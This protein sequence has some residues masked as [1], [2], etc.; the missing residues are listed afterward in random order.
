MAPETEETEPDT[1]SDARVSRRPAPGSRKKLGAAERA[2]H[3]RRR[4]WIVVGIAS[5]VSLLGVAVLVYFA[6]FHKSTVTGPRVPP[7]RPPLRV[8]SEGTGAYR[9]LVDALG[10]A[11]AG[12]RIVVETDLNENNVPVNPRHRNVIVEAMPNKTIVW[13]CPDNITDM[14]PDN[15]R[16]LTINGVEGFQ[17]K[18]ITLDGNKK[19]PVLISLY[20]RCPDLKLENLNL[21][22]FTRYGVQLTNC[23]GSKSAPVQL[24]DLTFVTLDKQSALFFTLDAQ[25]SFN[26]ITK[27][28]F[29]TVRGCRFNG[30]GGSKIKTPNLDFLDRT[31]I[32]LPAGVVPEQG[33]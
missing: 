1:D 27:I 19:A 4:F 11:Q 32:E 22:G 26:D 3:Q 13:K 21:S 12:D 5:G 30:A 15:V 28:R 17:L 33:S 23:E 14:P 7:P 24:I 9:R 6:F 31:A 10:H 8:N 29:I 25:K 20:G 18:G 2:A 16:L